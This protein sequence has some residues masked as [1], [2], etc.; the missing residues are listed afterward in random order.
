MRRPGSRKKR[1]RHRRGQSAQLPGLQCAY[2]EAT[3][4]YYGVTTILNLGTTD[5]STESIRALRARHAAG[6]LHA[7]YIYST[8]GHLT[9]QGTH[10]IYTIF[11]PAIR[12]AADSLAAATPV[13]EPVNLYSLGI[14]TRSE[15]LAGG[16]GADPKRPMSKVLSNVGMLQKQGV[17]VGVGTDTGNPYVFPGYSVH[18]ELELLASPRWRRSRRRPVGRPS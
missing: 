16:G 2:R 3:A 10:P 7:P 12:Q 1:A 13:D 15:L 5:G 9:L 14:R 11:S 4:L 18:R 6:T 8:G 17:L